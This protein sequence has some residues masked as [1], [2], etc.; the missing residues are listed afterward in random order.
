MKLTH[1]DVS[2]AHSLEVTISLGALNSE[3]SYLNYEISEG[4]G[5]KIFATFDKGSRNIVA[6]IAPPE[7]HGGAGIQTLVNTFHK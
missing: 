2:G 7:D 6:N 3:P 4:D 1:I 5:I